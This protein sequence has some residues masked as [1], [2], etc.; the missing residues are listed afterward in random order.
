M[1]TPHCCSKVHGHLL[2]SPADVTAVQSTISRS[3]PL[4]HCYAEREH[5]HTQDQAASGAP[6]LARLPLPVLL[7]GLLQE[8]AQGVGLRVLLRCACTPRASQLGNKLEQHTPNMT[9][10]HLLRVQRALQALLIWR[11]ADAHRLVSSKLV[12]CGRH[13]FWGA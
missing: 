1:K 10:P 13:T 7:H 2:R 4:A 6:A 3:L 8:E 12:H 9:S 11:G 5:L